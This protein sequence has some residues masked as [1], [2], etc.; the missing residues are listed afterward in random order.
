MPAVLRVP[1]RVG[2]VVRSAEAGGLAIVASV[3]EDTLL[4]AAP[5]RGR[6][7]AWNDGEPV[8]LHTIPLRFDPTLAGREL[9][10]ARWELDDIAPGRPVAAADKLRAEWVPSRWWLAVKAALTSGAVGG[11]SGT[12][13]QGII[14]RC[15]TAWAWLEAEFNRL[16][17]IPPLPPALPRQL[18][19]RPEGIAVVLAMLRDVWLD[20]KWTA[21][22][23]AEVG[24]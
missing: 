14:D 16:F 4:I 21:I 23:Q 3:T 9:R 8:E 15:D 7:G 5:P 24:L 20:A 13:V 22:W 1:V 12:A 18:P 6:S 11:G 17:V 19:P 10:S 2:D